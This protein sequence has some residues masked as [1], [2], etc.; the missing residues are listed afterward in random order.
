M[1]IISLF[2]DLSIY[3]HTQR[4]S[5][6]SSITEVRKGNSSLGGNGKYR[7]GQ[8]DGHGM[9]G[10]CGMDNVD[11]DRECIFYALRMGRGYRATLSRIRRCCL[12][13]CNGQSKQVKLCPAVQC[14]LWVY[15][16]G[17]R[18]PGASLQNA[19]VLPEIRS[20]GAF[21]DRGQWG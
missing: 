10:R 8:T 5:T 12:E 15:R 4:S 21:F 17:K 2:E 20:T 3:S 11:T 9:G 6:S 16:H 7:V 13:C 14:P 1:K 19:P 18:K